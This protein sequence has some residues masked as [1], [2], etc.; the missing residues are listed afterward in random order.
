MPFVEA[1]LRGS[2]RPRIRPRALPG[3]V[4]RFGPGPLRVPPQLSS[5]FR[6]EPA[7]SLPEG[8]TSAG[9]PLPEAQGQI[10]KREDEQWENRRGSGLGPND[11]ELNQGQDPA[12]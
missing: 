5:Q 9:P 3:A 11:G 6:L 7:G 2:L 8:L 12:E 1:R 4:A 10:L